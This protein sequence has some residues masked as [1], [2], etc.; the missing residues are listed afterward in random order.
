M[1]GFCI[2]PLYEGRLLIGL[3]NFSSS[4]FPLL[5]GKKLIAAMFYKLQ[6]EEIEEFKKPEATISEFPDDLINMMERYRPVST[7]NLLNEIYNIKNKVEDLRKEFSDM[8][9][10]FKKF[11]GSIEKITETLDKE[12]IERGT[13]D[14]NLQRQISE[15][16]REAYK[17]AG[18]VGG[19]GAIVVALLLFL[20][21]QL[22]LTK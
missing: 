14:Q 9:I 7:Q 3:Y 10:W 5:P 12:V 6:E 22:L 19:I 2:D 11:Q 13:S 15:Y 21:Q 18:M 1:G 8:D 4:P 17:I 20:I 16:T